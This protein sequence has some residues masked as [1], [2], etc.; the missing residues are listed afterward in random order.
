MIHVRGV[1]GG[2]P[3]TGTIYEQDNP[4]GERP[5]QF[6]GS[7]PIEAP[8]VSLCDAVYKVTSGGVSQEIA[9]NTIQVAFEPPTKRGFNKETTAVTHVKD[10]IETQFI[11]IGL[12]EE[13]VTF[14][15]LS[16]QEMREL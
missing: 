7:P 2:T 1:A 16:D 3:L 13:D 6:S 9:G 14:D 8:Y 5:P 12:S 11:R 10:H 4:N 15:I